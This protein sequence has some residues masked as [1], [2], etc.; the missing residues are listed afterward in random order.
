MVL[1][2]TKENVQDVF[3]QKNIT[4]LDFWAPWCGPCKMLG[5]VI[6]ALSVDE[7][8]KNITIGKVNVD[9]EGNQELAQKYS[10]RGIPTVI[11]FKDGE[12][13]VGKR[14]AGA[15]SQTELQAIIDSL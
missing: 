15:K 13:I 14:S 8:N 10:V 7:K 5:P 4:V 6:E 3:K 12:E 9:G 11:F 2:V 1:E